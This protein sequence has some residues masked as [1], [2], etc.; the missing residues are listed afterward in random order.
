MLYCERDKK[1][2]KKKFSGP[3]VFSTFHIIIT[4]ITLLTFYDLIQHF[5]RNFVRFS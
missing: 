1:K 3:R 2:E 4:I 5:G